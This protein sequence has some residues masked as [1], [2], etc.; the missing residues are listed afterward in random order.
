MQLLT[1]DDLTKI[2]N[3]SVKTIAV[4][5]NTGKLPYEKIEGPNFLFCSDTLIRYIT[6]NGMKNEKLIEHVKQ[7]LWETNPDAMKEIQEFGAHIPNDY[8][9]RT[10]YLNKIKNKKLGFVWYVRYIV[11]GVLLPSHWS[12]KTNDKE[13]AERW[14]IENRERILDKYYGRMTIKKSYGELYDILRKYYTKESKYLEIDFSRGKSIGETSR[15]AYHNFI[16]KQFIPYLK[17]HGIKNFEEIDTPFLA[18]F[19]NY[20]L[21][22][23]KTKNETVPGIKPQ[24]IKIYLLTVSNIFNHLLIA[25]HIKANPCKSLIKLKIKNEQLRGCYEITKLKGVFNKIWD[26]QLYYLLCL[27]IYTTGIRNS[28]IERM[29]TSCIITMDAVHF[30]N[31]TESKTKNGIRIV[32]LHDF[33]FRKLMTYIKKTKK[34]QCE[35]I[36]TYSASSNIKSGNSPL[37][38]IFKAS[39]DE[40]WCFSQVDR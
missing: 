38:R 5:A 14:A 10:H 13:T 24:T 40:I 29:R 6:N 3:V 37:K 16:I 39:A 12:T 15:K 23:R 35:L 20:L 22:T 18:R 30:I 27:I 26:N 9:A 36:C 2:F 33:V 32:P 19:Q 34:K 28:E 21:S 25:G 4:L 8:S 31:I 17:K 1:Q 11:N 7:K